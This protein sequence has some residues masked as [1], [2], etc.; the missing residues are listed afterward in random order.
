MLGRIYGNSIYY[1]IKT[2]YNPAFI[3]TTESRDR[4]VAEDVRSA[5]IIKPILRGRD[6]RRYRARWAGLWLI[7]TH[8]GYGNVPAVSVDEYPAVKRY[9]DQFY[10]RLEKRHD[11]GI[12]PYNLRNCAYHAE[13]S[14]E[15]LFW[16]DLT[17]EG[18]F[19]Y[20]TREQIFCA[21]SAYI[22]TANEIT[23][24]NR[25][26]IA[27]LCATLNAN[28]TTWFIK[29]I[30]LNSGMGVPRWIRSTV[31]QIP[32]PRL[33]PTDQRF[34]ADATDRLLDALDNSSH[35]SRKLQADLNRRV[36]RLYGLSTDEIRIVNGS[37]P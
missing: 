34:F 25:Y 8:N 9:L 17:E 3:I 2:G 22:L 5:E 29:Q 15:K 13:F 24:R 16:M 21:N 35:I 27:F 23:K 31:E 19:A 4:L 37:N 12:T 11:K 33:R 1:G 7:A 18:R 6:I 14:R 36:C 10:D 32:I 30:A 20:S 26:T 28:I